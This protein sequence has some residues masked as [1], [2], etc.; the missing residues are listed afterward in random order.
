[1][2]EIDISKAFTHAF[3]KM[4]VIG[5]FCKFD[6]WKPYEGGM[7]QSDLTIYYVKNL[8]F[9]KNRYMLNKEYCL[10]YGCVLK[11]I[12]HDIDIEIIA[13]KVPYQTHKVDYKTIVD[14]L[15]QMLI[16]DDV[17]EDKYIKKLIANVIIGL[18]EKGGATDQ[19]SLIFKNLNEAMSYQTEYGGQLHK[20]SDI[21]VDDEGY[22]EEKQNYYVLNLKDTI[23][24]K[25]GFRFIKEMLLQIHN[26]EMFKAYSKLSSNYIPCYSVK[27]DAFVI[28]SNYVEKAKKVLNFHGGIGGWRADKKDDEI[29]LPTVQ[30]ETVKNERVDIPTYECKELIVQD[31]YNTDNII[32]EHILPNKH[33]IIRGDVPGTGKSFI[34]QKMIEKDHNVIFVCPTI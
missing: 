7:E 6:V 28:D 26:L 32:E 3:S 17:Q 15:W 1:M 12:I 22:E 23:E 34:C 33:V 18:L 10:L 25:N 11:Q 16:S 14:R 19:K 21:E 20:L 31:E 30:Y 5:S 9:D 13:Y 4:L 27:A 2:T 29:I 24:L 8:N